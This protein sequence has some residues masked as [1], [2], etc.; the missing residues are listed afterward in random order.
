MHFWLKEARYPLIKRKRASPQEKQARVL[1][2]DPTLSFSICFH[3]IKC[4]Y[5]LMLVVSRYLV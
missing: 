2:S 4:I 3:D 5:S 1:M